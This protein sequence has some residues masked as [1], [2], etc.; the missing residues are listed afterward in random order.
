MRVQALSAML[1]FAPMC[2]MG[3]A[4]FDELKERTTQAARSVG[5]TA[6]DAFDAAGEAAGK[7]THAVTDSVDSTRKSLRDEPTPEETREKLDAMAEATLA[8]LFVEHPDTR[9]LFEQ[10]A[11]YAV[12]DAREASFYVVAGYGR[13]LAVQQRDDA[14]T[15]M[16]MATTGAGISFGIGGFENQLVILFEDDGDFAE[17]V[18]T[19]YDAG[20]QVGAM[21]GE[22]KNQ[23]KLRFTVGKAVFVLTKK[24]WKVD[25]RLTGSRYWPDD[26]LNFR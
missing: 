3:E 16:K 11:G 13:G 14:R 8:R 15:Y 7:A 4:S 5:E 1:L 20:A 25:A 26:E 17:F 10:S 24:G 9:D 12:F 22:D 2:A 18:R 21:V 6:G 19:G 23:L